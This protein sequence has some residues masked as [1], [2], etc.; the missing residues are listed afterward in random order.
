MQLSKEIITAS[1]DSINDTGS[2]LFWSGTISQSLTESI[3]EFGQTAPVLVRETDTGFMLIAGH[4]RL[5]V[6]RRL[7]QPVLVRLV[8]DVDARDLGLL[9]LADN[10]QRPMDDGMRLAA[11]RYFKP[12]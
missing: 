2:H 5:S 8:L 6:L 11:L 7:K 9:Y 10:G 1:A 3:E 12:S 4:A